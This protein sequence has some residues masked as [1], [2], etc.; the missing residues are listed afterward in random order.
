MANCITLVQMVM[1]P[2]AT[3]PPY[4]S[5]EELKHTEIML[6][7]ACITKGESPNATHGSKMAA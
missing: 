2:T 3:S 1:A 6:S 4:F 5:K 7:L